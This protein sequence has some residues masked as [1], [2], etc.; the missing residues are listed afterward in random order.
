[1][2]E[3]TIKKYWEQLEKDGLIK[4]CPHGWKEERDENGLLVSF[5]KRW[6]ERNKHKD[7]YY[8]IPIKQ[9]MLFRK[10]PKTTLVDL[11]EIYQVN[12]LTLKV[13]MTMINYQ[14]LCNKNNKKYKKF[15]YMDLRE[16]LGYS[17]QNIIDRKLE[18]SLNTLRSLGLIKYEAGTFTNK[19]GATIPVFVLTEANFY[20]TYELKDFKPE[21]EITISQEEKLEI[22]NKNKELYPEAFN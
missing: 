4:F 16:I 8:E 18:A 5:N 12:E 22:I 20:I 9:D 6:K 1:M 2:D 7:T 13:Y 10:I 17:K 15:T 14:E 19:Y 11:N 3:R 21:E